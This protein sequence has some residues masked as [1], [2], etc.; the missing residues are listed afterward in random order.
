MS[1]HV[2]ITGA[3]RGIGRGIAQAFFDLGD[4]VAAVDRRGLGP[5]IVDRRVAALAADITDAA[6]VDA[7]FERAEAQFGKVDVLVANAGVVKDR[8]LARLADQDF[9]DVVGTNLTGTF[10]C[11]RRAARSMMARRSGA[12]ILIGSVV[13]AVGGVGQANYAAS[14]AAL[15]GLARAVAREL[16]PR[17]ITANVVAPGFIETDMT[18]GLPEPVRRG[19]L[20]QIPAGRFGS[21]HDVAGAATF[22]ASAPYVNGAVIPV[23]GGLGMGH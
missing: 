22:L 1:R 13:G 23:D 5:G 9:A 6:Q 4:N 12:I 7:A 17:G 14:K 8:P 20:A 3:S 10:R 16:G 21:A 19:H 18:D 15:V 2:F 11:V